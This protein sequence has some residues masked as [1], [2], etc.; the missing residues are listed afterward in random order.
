[1]EPKEGTMTETLLFE[2]IS[3]RLHR[4]ARLAREDRTRALLSLSHHMDLG[5]MREA[6]E[7]TRKDGARGV[8]DGGAEEFARNLEGNL[9][10]L[11]DRAK[12][13]TYRAPPVR[14]VHIPKSDGKTRPL[15]IPTF[16]DK[17]L[18]RAVAMVLEA[19]YEQD[20][21]D[22]SYGFRPGRSARQAVHT[23]WQGLMGMGGG[24]VLEVD[25]RKFFDTL[26]HAHLREILSKRVRDG[27]IA[28]LVGKWL[29]AGVMEDGAI[30]YPESGTPQGGVISPILAN[31]Y[32]HE[33]LDV[34]FYEE[35]RP[36]LEGKA[37]LVRY[38]DD[39][40]IVFS[41]ERDARRVMDVLPKR[42]GKFGL[43]L[44]PDKTGLV[45]FERPEPSD[46]DGDDDGAGRRDPRAFDFLG[47][48]HHW[49]K[50]RKGGFAVALRT[51]A[52]RFRRTL[53]RITAWC[54]SHRHDPIAEQARVLAAKVRG[55]FNY[56]GQPGNARRMSLLRHQV[57]QIWWKWLGRR[58]QRPLW[59][60][61][62]A[63][64]LRRHPLPRPGPFLRAGP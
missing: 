26:E 52:D 17:V 6:Y 51:A 19:V 22:C 27:V 11:L 35:V 60:H 33:V 64:I 1:M 37:F 28:R 29:N 49:V 31:I 4:V 13:G 7:R 36:R 21:M 53:H 5:L 38:A 8:D 10:S 24:W 55:H 48:T 61:Q 45:R 32:L 16:E 63:L 57:E 50:T 2:N 34:W 12:S 46:D 20:F 23:L 41:E 40:V 59:W 54:Q 15:G 14:R 30:S 9:L 47:F 44:H 43:A 58:S 3:P 39:F 25:I 62:M 18:Q 42:F 56:F